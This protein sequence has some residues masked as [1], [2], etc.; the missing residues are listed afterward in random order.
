[1]TKVISVSKA[2]ENIYKLID[3]TA[4]SGE[5]ILITGKRNNAVMMSEEDYRAIEET[6]FLNSIPGMVDSLQ[7]SMS[8]PD[9]EFSEE[10]EW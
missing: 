8:A 9:S 1:M 5:P 2:R 4:I 10:I 3:E 7:K 6:I